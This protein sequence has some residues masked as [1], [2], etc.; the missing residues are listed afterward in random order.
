M[1]GKQGIHEHKIQVK[2]TL[3]GEA[4]V[5]GWNEMRA[6]RP[7]KVLASVLGASFW[8]FT[9]LLKGI[10]KSRLCMNKLFKCDIN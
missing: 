10:S 8:L 5:M 3:A 7:L 6:G 1:K 4:R 9:T 2:V